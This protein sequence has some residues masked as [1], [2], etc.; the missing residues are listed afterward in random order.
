MK[1]TPTLLLDDALVH[2]HYEKLTGIWHPYEIIKHK[3]PQML[4]KSWGINAR[5]SWRTRETFVCTAETMAHTQPVTCPRL[6]YAQFLQ[7]QQRQPEIAMIYYHAK[8][9]HACI[10][11]QAL[12]SRYLRQDDPDGSNAGLFNIWNL[13]LQ[14][15]PKAGVLNILCAERNTVQKLRTQCHNPVSTFSFSL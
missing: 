4:N 15:Y 5:I 1:I 2:T 7:K 13:M 8:A 12:L 10:F 9:W 14:Q 3:A 6:R 11:E